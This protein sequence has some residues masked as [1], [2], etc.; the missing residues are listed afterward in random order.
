MYPVYRSNALRRGNTDL[1]FNGYQ[2]GQMGV[3]GWTGAFG[4][5]H[6]YTEVYEMT[7]QRGPA[8]L[9]R[10]LYLT[11]CDGLYGKRI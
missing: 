9:H 3:V 2:R 11:F 5:W 7:G 1:F 4:D 8:V 10:E 6:I